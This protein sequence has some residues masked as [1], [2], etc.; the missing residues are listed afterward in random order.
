M[1]E[2]LR[3]VVNV[4]RKEHSHAHFVAQFNLLLLVELINVGVGKVLQSIGVKL[5]VL[6][7]LAIVSEVQL[8]VGGVQI[9]F[10]VLLA[11]NLLLEGLNYGEALADVNLDQGETLHG[12]NDELCLFGQ[13][14]VLLELL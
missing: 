13:S 14:A 6:P 3:K 2:H 10:D 4:L 8:V 12:L 1:L 7:L 9:L 5:A 11:F